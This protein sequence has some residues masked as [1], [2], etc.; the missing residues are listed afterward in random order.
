MLFQY[1][2]IN[3]S[4]PFMHNSFMFAF[5]L[6]KKIIHISVM[7]QYFLKI[8]LKFLGIPSNY[9]KFYPILLFFKNLKTETF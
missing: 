7:C 9:N 5:K 8:V 1:F 3:F 4:I 6:I 2:L